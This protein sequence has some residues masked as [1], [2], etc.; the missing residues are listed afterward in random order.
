MN[1]QLFMFLV[2]FQ[3]KIQNKL[4]IHSFSNVRNFCFPASLGF[5]ALAGRHLG[6]LEV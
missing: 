1:Q 3:A 2:T 4:S 6:L 5:G